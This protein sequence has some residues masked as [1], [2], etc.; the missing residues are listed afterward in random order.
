MHSQIVDDLLPALNT[1]SFDDFEVFIT[2]DK[3]EKSDKKLEKNYSWL[4]I[5]EAKENK[6]PGIKRD[7]CVQRSKGDV[8]VF[9]D[10]DVI[11]PKPWLQN[12]HDIFE[13]DASIAALGGPGSLPPHVNYWEHVFDAILTSWLG[14][15][16]FTYRFQKERARYVDDFPSMNLMIR[17]K[18]FL[19]AGG[20][21][22]G[23]WPGEDSKLLDK[24]KQSDGGCI[25]Y[26]PN[27]EV[28]HHRRDALLGHLEQYK[29]YGRMRGLFA[30]QG[31]AN[32]IHFI[33]IIPSMFILYCLVVIAISFI[34]PTVL[35]TALVPLFIYLGL[36]LYVF[37]KTSVATES[38]LIGLGATL[39]I[40]L[41][42]LNYGIWYIIGYVREKLN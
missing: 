35:N 5:I 36:L 34:A 31:D 24:F 2:S 42:H 14:S 10:D 8:L 6:R 22:N 41:T 28:Y 19:K 7:A 39:V 40:P 25:Y 12:A 11:P 27:T 26:H 17:K 23:Y 21:D 16:S 13:K 20:F 38:I 4:H 1:Q 15:G 33:Y 3:A 32:S 9:I 37:L 18:V 30:A 29:N